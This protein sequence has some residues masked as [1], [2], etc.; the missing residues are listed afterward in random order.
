M[1]CFG[2]ANDDIN[3][4]AI[5][6]DI[7]RLE[8][9]V[10]DL[11]VLGVSPFDC[12]RLYNDVTLADAPLLENWRLSVRPVPCLEGLSTGHP[13]LPGFRRLIVTSE[14]SVFSPE[15]GLARSLSR[16]FRLGEPR[17]YALKDS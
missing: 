14:I 6:R 12:R 11:W 1:H 3:R 4:D 7:E 9:L 10:A 5:I 16:W 15:L 17:R 2:N 13:L 8:A